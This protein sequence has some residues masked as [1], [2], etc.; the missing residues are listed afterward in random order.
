MIL[1]S[2]LAQLR[3]KCGLT[4]VEVANHLCRNA[5]KGCTFKAVS[6]WENGVS[7]PNVEQ[8]LL[9]CELYGVQD[10]QEAFR[11]QKIEF[12][13]FPKLNKLG[14]SHVE[15]YIA[16]LFGNPLFVNSMGVGSYV[17]R[18]RIIRLYDLPAVTG[19]GSF[20]ESGTYEDFVVD[21]T[22]AIDADYAVRASGDSMVP[23]FLDRQIVFIK[24]RQ[25]LD[26]DDI[27]VFGLDGGVYLKKW[28]RGELISL[29]P[30]YGPMRVH[31]HSL[32]HI[33]GKVL[34]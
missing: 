17:G 13:S 19:A 25:S 34:G 21:N 7:M 2:V 26:I 1:S 9:L 32:F 23:R 11:G 30:L 29:N 31:E 15:D 8:F 10:I 27:G 24:E 14:R 20:L 18:Q 6:N 4:Q 22:V 16:V 28:G 3:R 12:R 5:D 33:F